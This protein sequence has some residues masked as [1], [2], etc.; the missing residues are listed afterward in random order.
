MSNNRNKL[1][2]RSIGPGILSKIV[3]GGVALFGLPII[4]NKTSI[5][6]YKIFL[7]YISFGAL[8]TLPIGI[9]GNNMVSQLS[10]NNAKNDTNSKIYTLELSWS[11][12]RVYS[13]ISIIIG[14]VFSFLFQSSALVGLTVISIVTLTNLFRWSEYVR[15][16]ERSDYKSS[17]ILLISNTIF[18]ST[19]LLVERFSLFGINITYFIFPLISFSILYFTLSLRLN[20]FDSLVGLKKIPYFFIESRFFAIIQAVDYFKIYVTPIVITIFG[21][22][23]EYHIAMTIILFCARLINPV[24]LIVRPLF[25]AFIEA[26][27]QKD[28]VWLKRF[29]T[30]FVTSF[31]CAVISVTLITLSFIDEV[32]YL[33]FKGMISKINYHDK[34]SISFFLVS[35]T[36][37]NLMLP[38]FKAFENLD[39]LSKTSL[40][41]TIFSFIIGAL[42]SFYADLD[43]VFITLSCLSLIQCLHLLTVMKKLVLNLK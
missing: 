38:I 43:F 33:L 3:G 24:S 1:I 37:L 14:Y 28:I 23:N 36:F 42:L 21:S 5:N 16:S 32:F 8:L 27:V 29:L 13:I 10:F 41:V 4:A 22:P 2:L 31:F 30:F 6:D 18:L 35:Q 12:F 11:I 34:F 15:I 17:I 20:L 25:P 40:V 7:E 19:L 9:I 26:Y 39:Y